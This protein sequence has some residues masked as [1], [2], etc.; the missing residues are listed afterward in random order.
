[1]IVGGATICKPVTTELST[2]V[3]EPTVQ[4]AE[5][6]Y[7]PTLESVMLVPDKP[8]DQFI[9]P[10]Q[11]LAA[12]VK[13]FGE[14]TIFGFGALMIGANGWVIICKP[15]TVALDTLVQLPTV[16]VAEML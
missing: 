3:Q 8:F 11:P 7:V 2:L 5:I 14:Q 10:A 13:I 6:E 15:V 12:N 4:V 1:M 9:V 16:Q